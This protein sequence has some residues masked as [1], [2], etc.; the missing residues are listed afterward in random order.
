MNA[1]VRTTLLVLTTITLAASV[2]WAETVNLASHMRCDPIYE[3]ENCLGP[4]TYFRN[5][6][7]IETG[8]NLQ[9][10]TSRV[11]TLPLL[12]REIPT[13]GRSVSRAVPR[14]PA[15]TQSQ[16]PPPTEGGPQQ[17]ANGGGDDG[18]QFEPSDTQGAS[19]N[20]P[21]VNVQNPGSGVT[22]VGGMMYAGDEE[23][24][25]IALPGSASPGSL[26]TQMTPQQAALN[27]NQGMD[28]GSGSSGGGR[29]P[30]AASGGG[31]GVDPNQFG[32]VDNS[33]TPTQS[34][35]GD[36]ITDRL[37]AI[38]SALGQGALSVAGSLG[39]GDGGESGGGRNL[40]SVGLGPNG[41][42]LATGASA[43]AQQIARS[44]KLRTTLQDAFGRYISS[45]RTAE[46]GAAETLIFNGMCGHYQAYAAKYGIPAYEDKACEDAE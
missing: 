28:T 42:P 38:A 3:P 35:G 26:A 23:T 43:R 46:F 31:G 15:T 40:A 21:A 44:D 13:R 8:I 25:P 29:G 30:A 7:K 36:G 19:M 12:S 34:A 5:S 16:T 2:S 45:S 24:T 17:A 33:P 4:K 1:L 20:Q 41:K 22:T 18:F 14:G 11:P 27:V 32:Q 10:P 6:L 39:M 9:R 37:K